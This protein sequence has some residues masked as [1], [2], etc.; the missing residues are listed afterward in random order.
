MIWDKYKNLGIYTFGLDVRRSLEVFDVDLLC[1]CCAESKGFL[2]GNL[3][4]T[5]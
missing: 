5:V 3:W 2:G 1:R 4:V